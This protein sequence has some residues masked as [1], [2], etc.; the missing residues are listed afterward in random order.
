MNKHHRYYKILITLFIQF[1]F[2]IYT[3]LI[4]HLTFNLTDLC[5]LQA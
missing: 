4:Y 5:T 2:P 3:I 1:L